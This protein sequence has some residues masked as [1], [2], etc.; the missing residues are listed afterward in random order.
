MVW[1]KDTITGFLDANRR[2]L[3]KHET[4]LLFSKIIG[5]YN[6]QKIKCNPYKRLRTGHTP[7]V[8]SGCPRINTNN[9]G[10]LFPTSI[11]PFGRDSIT[12]DAQTI[13]PY[14]HPTKKPQKILE[15]LIK[16]Y[17][18]EGDIILDPFAGSGTTGDAAI[19]TDRKFILVEKEREYYDKIVNRLQASQTKRNSQLW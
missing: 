9:N 5:Y 14:K 10:E 8:Y 7:D 6:P 3:R 13:D 18:N 15:Y 16:T 17:S 1:E 19:Q 11:L 2:H 4:I 12:K